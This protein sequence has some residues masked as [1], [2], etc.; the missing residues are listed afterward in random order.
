MTR[1]V[2]A[3]LFKL[4]TMHAWWIITLATVVSTTATLVV[5]CVQAHELLKSFHQYLVLH[6]HDHADKPPADFVAQLRSE[7][8][9]GHSAVTQAATI[10]TSG[11]RLVYFW[12]PCSGSLC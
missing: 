2:R 1:L 8:T 4:R 6:T 10:Y 5:N 7:W 9:L 11:Q 3:E 12:P